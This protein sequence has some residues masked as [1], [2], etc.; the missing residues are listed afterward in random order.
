MLPLALR[1]K[2]AAFLGGIFL[3]A[4]L[5]MVLG[6]SLSN[7]L[8]GEAGGADIGGTL[9]KRPPFFLPSNSGCILGKTPPDAMVTCLSSWKR[10]CHD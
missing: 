6:G 4:G 8:A 3:A 1:A 10:T 2:V 5:M 7:F 9:G